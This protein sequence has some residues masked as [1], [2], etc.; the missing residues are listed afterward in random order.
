MLRLRST[1][2]KMDTLFVLS[3]FALFASTTFVLIILGLRQYQTTTATM[4]HNDEIRTAVSYLREQIRQADCNSSISVNQFYDTS[5]ITISS[6][7]DNAFCYSYIYFYDGYLRELTVRDNSLPNPESGKKLIALNGLDF[8]DS[9]P[10][11]IQVTLEDSN[12]NQLPLYLSV[13]S[14]Y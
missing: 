8:K 9:S 1:I 14:I 13:K 2:Q 3:L 12:G 7:S 6:Q 10:D 4:H 5:A 11:L